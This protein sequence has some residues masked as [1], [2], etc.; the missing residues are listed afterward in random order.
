[1]KYVLIVVVSL[2][3]I[4]CGV[5]VDPGQNVVVHKLNKEC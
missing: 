1:M 5:S 3:L 4:G 2:L